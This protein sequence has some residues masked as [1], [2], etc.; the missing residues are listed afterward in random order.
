MTLVRRRVTAQAGSV[1]LP[2]AVHSTWPSR[3]IRLGGPFT[4]GGT[5]DLLPRAMA[6]ELQ[7]AL[8]Q[9]VIVD[10]SPAPAATSAA[11]SS[12]RPPTATRC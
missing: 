1:A 2:A 7:R 5:T 9:P 6:P 4:P 10:N 8:G 12:P 3:P 11:P